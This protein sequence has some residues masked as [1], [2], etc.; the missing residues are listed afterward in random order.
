M[1]FIRLIDRVCSLIKSD[2]DFE[3]VLI[4]SDDEIVN[5]DEIYNQFSSKSN[6]VLSDGIKELYKKRPKMKIEWIKNE[7]YGG[8]DMLPIDKLLEE[9]DYLNEYL[10]SFL[11]DDDRLISFRES[12]KKLY[13]IFDFCSG[14]K[15]CINNETE[16]IVYYDY[17]FLEGTG[18]DLCGLVIARDF[19][20]LIEHWSQILF[21]EGFWWYDD[22][23]R[24]VDSNGIDLENPYFKKF[25]NDL[26][27]DR[28]LILGSSD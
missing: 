16:Q 27:I 14:D 7:Y 13:P 5:F 12:F 4:S 24:G 21:L 18:D 19:D 9:H 8:F 15:L 10:E 1:D 22:F 17:S 20:Y 6:I 26:N 28:N 25:W 3:R 2:G 11:K 23:N